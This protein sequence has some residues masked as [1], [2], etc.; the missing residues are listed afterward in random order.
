MN[1]PLADGYTLTVRACTSDDDPFLFDVYASTRVKEFACLN[2][3]PARMDSLLRTQFAAR[4]RSYAERFPR[5]ENGIICRGTQTLG[6]IVVNET[7]DEIH[8]VDIALAPRH[9]GAGHGAALIRGLQARAAHAGKKVCLEVATSNR[10]LHLYER[11]GFVRTGDTG[12]HVMMEWGT[13]S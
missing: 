2:W 12:I 8:L 1:I 7:D 9:R 10:A 3:D 13:A 4:S 11:L 6:Y 5:A